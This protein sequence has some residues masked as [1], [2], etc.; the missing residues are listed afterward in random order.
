MSD[1]QKKKTARKQE[2]SKQRAHSGSSIQTN[3]KKGFNKLDFL[4]DEESSQKSKI[5]SDDEK[6]Q[7]RIARVPPLKIVLARTVLQKT[8]DIER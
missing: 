4:R 6:F 3:E 2:N 1:E 7:D 8:P 5:T